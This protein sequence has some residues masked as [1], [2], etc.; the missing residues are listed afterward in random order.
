MVEMIE[1]GLTTNVSL[2]HFK[3]ILRAEQNL[4]N[5]K[6]SNQNKV[7][8]T[9]SLRSAGLTVIRLQDLHQAIYLQTY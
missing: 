7:K 2:M 1:G 5:D 8:I 9:E 4:L 3:C 6:F